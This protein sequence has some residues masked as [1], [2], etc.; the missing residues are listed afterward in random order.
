[1]VRAP[2]PLSPGP[3]GPVRVTLTVLRRGMGRLHVGQT[4]RTA[5][6]DR[7]TVVKSASPR[8]HSSTPVVSDSSPSGSAVLRM[9]APAVSLAARAGPT[10]AAR[11]PDSSA[12]AAAVTPSGWS[13]R[14]PATMTILRWSPLP[15]GAPETGA[16][17]TGAPDTGASVGVSVPVA[18]LSAGAAV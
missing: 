16:P 9:A 4:T 10:M 8:T 18:G 7:S 14:I 15:T 2:L 3:V 12:R 6:A 13:P 17:D 5:A 11:R 1:S